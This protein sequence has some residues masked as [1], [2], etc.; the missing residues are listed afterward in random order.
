[1]KTL[2]GYLS[3]FFWLITIVA[4]IGWGTWILGQHL[5]W[6]WGGFWSNFISN[7]GSS[8][9]IAVVL[10]WIITRRDE[11]NANAKRRA[12]ALSMLNIEFKI[13]LERVKNYGEA[14]KTPDDDLTPFYPLRL[15]R[16]AWNALKESG[17][18]PQFDDIGFV[19]EL[20]RLNEV[21]VVANKSL[22]S[23]RS[24]KAG[25]NTKTK[26]VRYSKKAIRECAQIEAYLGPILSK[27]EN[28]DLPEIKM[29][30]EVVDDSNSDD[31]DTP[32]GEGE[33]N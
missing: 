16:G 25:R 8:A 7:A 22:A 9:V 23:V 14:L 3:K 15:T 6:D 19:Y 18:L 2:W 5:A 11:E 26:L 13:N 4:S 28:M 1:M 17:F 32:E 30:A 33:N 12:K 21:I 10:Y 29:P 24:A 27:L 20:L 31:D